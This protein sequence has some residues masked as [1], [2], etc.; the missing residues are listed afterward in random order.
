MN[1]IV[2]GRQTGR[3]DEI[4]RMCAEDEKNGEISYIIC[5]SHS[6]VRR[7]FDRAKELNLIIRFPLTFN[8]FLNKQYYSKT[9]RN[10]YIDNADLLLQSMTTINIKAITMEETDG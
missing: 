8:E 6:E 5:M 4:I 9:I 1:I 10:F 3:T 7:I 2:R